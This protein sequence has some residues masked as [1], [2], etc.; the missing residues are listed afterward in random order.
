MNTIIT[1]LPNT[2]AHSSGV[3]N[4]PDYITSSS[5]YLN[6]INS[7]LTFS[8][9][10]SSFQV[11]VPANFDSDITIKGVSLSNTL[12]DIQKKLL[13]LTPDP[14]KLEKWDALQKAYD[15]YKILEA[16]LHEDDN[17]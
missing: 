10:K 13:I 8:N 2:M 6:T 3:V 5:Y 14:K 1:S 7:N 17:E 4:I 15:R 9:P 16:L 11:D 12:A